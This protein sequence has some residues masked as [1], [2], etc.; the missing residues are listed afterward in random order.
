MG[1]A[2]LSPNSIATATG[3]CSDMMFRFHDL[4]K[5]VTH[6]TTSKPG[7]ACF[8]RARFLEELIK[9]IP[10][11][12]AHFGKSLASIESANDETGNLILHFA[13]GTTVTASAVIACDGIKSVVRRSYILSETPDAPTTRPVSSLEYAYRGMYSKAEFDALTKGQISSNKGTIFCGNDGYFVMYPVDK[14]E[15]MNM[16]AVKRIPTQPRMNGATSVIDVPN[17]SDSSWVK[18]VDKET[19][20]AEFSDWG[21]HLQALISAV[22]RPERWFLFDHLPAPTYFRGNVAILGD[23]A[24]ASTPHQGQGAGMAFEDSLIMSHALGQVL[25]TTLGT[26]LA[27]IADLGSKV[28]AAFRAYDEVRRPR[29]QRICKTSREAGEMLEYVLPEIGNDLGKMEANLATRMD[30]IWDLDLEAEVQRTVEIA[31]QILD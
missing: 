18:A 21:E 30:W 26:P 13:D 5:T 15:F 19:M 1:K 2:E 28:E 27:D 22:Q 9:L 25:G 20:E 29:T 23:S 8:H 6:T 11:S 7:R 17:H 4:I 24:H 10:P 3:H 14:G 12:I 31:R 16:V